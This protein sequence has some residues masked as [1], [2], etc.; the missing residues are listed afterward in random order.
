MGQTWLDDAGLKA[1]RLMGT[2][3]PQQVATGVLK[4]IRKDKAE[5]LVGP[6]GAKFLTQSPG[7]ASRMFGRIGAWELMR[8]LGEAR[9]ATTAAADPG[10][11]A[12]PTA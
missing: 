7:F 9:T 1:P 12:R 10:P 4:A 3:S 6:P 5:L 8:R 2:V 11:E